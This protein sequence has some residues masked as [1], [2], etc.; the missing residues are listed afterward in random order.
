M[1]QTTCHMCHY[2]A[3]KVEQ[4]TGRRCGLFRRTVGAVYNTRTSICCSLRYV[5]RHSC[6]SGALPWMYPR[7]NPQ[8]VKFVPWAA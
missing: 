7:T 1:T 4:R 6:D 2:S 5:G 8:N 3:G